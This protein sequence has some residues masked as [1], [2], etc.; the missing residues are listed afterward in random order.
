MP[1]GFEPGLPWKYLAF[2][3]RAAMP[4]ASVVQPDVREIGP[5]GSVGPCREL[6]GPCRELNGQFGSIPAGDEAAG[7][8]VSTP[9]SDDQPQ[10]VTTQAE[11]RHPYNVLLPFYLRFRTL[12]QHF[13][14]TVC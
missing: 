11:Y 13:I 10:P 3:H 9:A 1:S 4:F 5:G 12:Y 14:F 7:L 6:S 8:P 2:C